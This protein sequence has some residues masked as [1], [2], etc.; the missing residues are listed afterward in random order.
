[1]KDKTPCPNALKGKVLDMVRERTGRHNPETIDGVKIWFDDGSSVLL[2]PSGTEPAFRIFAE[3]DSANAARVLA[4]RYKT[5]VDE[6]VKA[7]GAT[8]G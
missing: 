8:I 5:M 7:L 3:A 6:M 1:V 4:D 2:R